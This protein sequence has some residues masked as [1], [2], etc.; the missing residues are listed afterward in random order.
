MATNN[1]DWSP[2]YAQPTGYYTAL[3]PGS[4][5]LVAPIVPP[6]ALP[7]I[8]PL[9]GI[10]I[11]PPPAGTELAEFTAKDIADPYATFGVGLSANLPSSPNKFFAVPGAQM[12]DL[13]DTSFYF[14]FNIPGNISVENVAV[15]IGL[16]T[17]PNIQNVDPNGNQAVFGISI[18]PLVSGSSTV[19]NSTFSTEY[20]TLTGV[21]PTAASTFYQFIAIAGGSLS[22]GNIHVMRL[23]RRAGSQ[24]A[25][26]SNRGRLLLINL[27]VLS[28]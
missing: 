9:R 22:P 8:P 12:L 1:V 23:S 25:L 24:A 14:S 28:A 19:D 10:P 2:T 26:D 18:A 11:A 7:A 4:R 3:A 6:Q 15:Q 13:V 17:D 20:F 21:L 5:T 16:C 27:I